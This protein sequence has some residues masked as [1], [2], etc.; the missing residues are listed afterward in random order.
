MEPTRQKP[1]L[2]IKF[3]FGLWTF[4]WIPDD[5]NNFFFRP[6]L[7]GIPWIQ[8]L[9]ALRDQFNYTIRQ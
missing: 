6:Q 1:S 8:T 7:N 9:A 4:D 3:E 5:S 2:T